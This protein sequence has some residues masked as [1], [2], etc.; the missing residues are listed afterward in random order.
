MHKNWIE[1]SDRRTLPYKE[2]LA[3]FN[4]LKDA[5]LLN[6]P[7]RKSIGERFCSLTH[8]CSKLELQFLE[9][10]VQAK[11]SFKIYVLAV[12]SM[13]GLARLLGLETVTSDGESYDERINSLKANA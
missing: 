2:M 5:G 10:G 9:G 6:S 3:H 4:Q 12:N 1:N 13:A 7:V 8:Y 11:E